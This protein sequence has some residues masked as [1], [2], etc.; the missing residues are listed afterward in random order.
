MPRAAPGEVL[1]AV[2]ASGVYPSNTRTR[3]GSHAVTEMSFP[4]LIPHQDGAGMIKNVGEG[5]PARAIGER[6]WIYEAQL[7]RPF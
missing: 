5:R 7:G 1:V 6:V 2:H 3:S 4:L